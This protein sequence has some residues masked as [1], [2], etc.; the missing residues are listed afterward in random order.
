MTR[1]ASLS[2]QAYRSSLWHLKR[3]N[4]YTKLLSFL[5]GP[6]LIIANSRRLSKLP[7]IG[8]LA[9][10]CNKLFV[11]H[12]TAW[13]FEE[14]NLTNAME[15]VLKVEQKNVSLPKFSK[16]VIIG[17]G[18]GAVCAALN[19]PPN[20]YIVIE[21][22]DSISGNYGAHN[23]SQV[24][25]DFQKAGQEVILSKPLIQFGQGKTLGGG[26]EVN[27][28]LYHQT[29]SE[30]ANEWISA[31]SGT[32]DEWL[33]SQSE[34]E[35]F[36]R[37]NHDIPG[38]PNDSMIARSAIALGYEYLKVPRWRKYKNNEVVN[39]F[40]M[41]ELFWETHNQN[42]YC[43]IEVTRIKRKSHYLEVIAR[44]LSGKKITV[45]CDKVV[46]SA[47]TVATPLILFKSRLIKISKAKFNLHVMLRSL[48]K[49]P[50]TDLGSNDIDPFQA[51]SIDHKLKFGSAVSSPSLLS[52]TF[53]RE[54]N[55]GENESLR[56]FYVSFAP[57][58]KGG[59]VPILGLP[60]FIFNKS[61]RKMFAR[62]AA[63]LCFTI[64]SDK[65]VNRVT[66]V[67]QIAKN[68][69]TVHIF[70]SLPA[71]GKLINEYGELRRDKRIVISDGSLLPT[72]PLVNP[73]GPIMTLCNLL[74][75]RRCL[76]E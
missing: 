17:S 6:L 24:I 68:A 42:I 22:G 56:A 65:L 48:V 47:G 23:L 53:G 9:A 62:A 36:L 43:G 60:Y 40:G 12:K 13:K 69:S 5:F 28:G 58:G 32:R 75:K 25:M 27:S 1:K 57:S 33:A 35:S 51:W 72:A 64:D 63:Q 30:I 71:G 39:H 66:A 18:P 50:R 11:T 20:D 4:Y 74:A 16:V 31:I 37:V 2:A 7:F 14:S 70:G 45:R 19:T 49:V 21:S 46:L 3:G 76:N 29:P 8:D 59:F 73:Q 34:M 26:S 61:D 67:S 54:L 44:D 55:E 52:S 10:L 38:S 15:R 41:R